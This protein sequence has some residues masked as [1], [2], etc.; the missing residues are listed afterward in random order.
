MAPK[1]MKIIGYNGKVVSLVG[2]GYD[3]L[4]T[5]FSDYALDVYFSD[6]EV[7]KI[8]LKMIDRNIEIEYLK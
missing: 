2:F 4:G 7:E 1:K 6:K 8:L 3:L 5:S